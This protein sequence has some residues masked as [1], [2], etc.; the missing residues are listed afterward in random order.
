MLMIFAEP[1]WKSQIP[2]GDKVMSYARGEVGEEVSRTDCAEA[3]S[4]LG[5]T[6]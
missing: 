4:M 3:Q 5:E 6:S 1:A 2:L